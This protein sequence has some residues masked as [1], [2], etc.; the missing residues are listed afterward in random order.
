[1]AHGVGVVLAPSVEGDLVC[2]REGHLV[3][4]LGLH[5]L[6]LPRQAQNYH[7]FLYTFKNPNYSRYLRRSGYKFVKRGQPNGFRFRPYLLPLYCGAS[8]R[9]QW[10]SRFEVPEDWPFSAEYWWRDICWV[11]LVNASKF[12]LK[13]LCPLVVSMLMGHILICG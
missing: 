5:P 3:L 12:K 13:T 11:L 7:F 6:L 2:L 1:V 4:I 9:I 8:K 10:I